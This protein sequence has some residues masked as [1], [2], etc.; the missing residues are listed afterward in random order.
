MEKML[1]IVFN[2]EQKAYEGSDA[3]TELD[4]EGDIAL[5]AEAIIQK[6]MLG[7]VK[8]V[9]ESDDLPVRT[10]GGTAIGALIGLLEG[11]VA[12]EG[13]GA[14][15]GS[16]AGAMADMNHAGVDAEFLD[17]V[18]AKLKRGKWAVVADVS[19][20]RERPVDKRMEAIGGTVVRTAR[21][22]VEQEQ[23]AKEVAG[24]KDDINK[25]KE[26]KDK[27]SPSEKGKIQKKIDDLKKKMHAKQEHAKERSKQEQSEA[28]SKIESLKKKA[29]KAKS[30]EKAKFEAWKDEIK[31]KSDKSKETSDKLQ[32]EG[33]DQ[34]GQGKDAQP[35]SSAS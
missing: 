6:N 8:V 3:L 34:Q 31:K 27:A 23:Y 35:T 13:A 11:G 7:K 20:D 9:K 15:A 14:V 5:Y 28:K 30:D 25:Q 24:T 1:V 4:S 12:G 32:Q 22:E 17:E 2:D 33:T 29:A 18:S 10:A 21:R 26:E 19:E 16:Y